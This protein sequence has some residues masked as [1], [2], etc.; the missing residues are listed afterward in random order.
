MHEQGLAEIMVVRRTI[1]PPEMILAAFTVG[2]GKRSV[3]S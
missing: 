2:L 1:D 3:G